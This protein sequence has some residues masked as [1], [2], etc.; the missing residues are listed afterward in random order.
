[1]SARNDTLQSRRN[2]RRNKMESQREAK[3]NFDALMK[4]LRSQR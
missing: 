3:R 4:E 2:D 1:M